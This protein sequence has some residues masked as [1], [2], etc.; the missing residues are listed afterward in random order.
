MS[1]EA[2]G[3]HAG[4]RRANDQNMFSR[5]QISLFIP[6]QVTHC[7]CDY[8]SRPY[9]IYRLTN[10]KKQEMVNCPLRNRGHYD[11]KVPWETV[12]WI[13]DFAEIL[14]REKK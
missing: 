14:A 2:V 5:P 11:R 7:L 4:W 6:P 12:S 9:I 3:M 10:G 1:W 8:S 13:I